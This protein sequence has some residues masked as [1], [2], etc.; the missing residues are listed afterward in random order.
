MP[1]TIESGSDLAGTLRRAAAAHGKRA[2]QADP[3]WPGCYVIYVV[4]EQTGRSCPH[5]E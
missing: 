1:T 4:R 3:D 2:G 5:D